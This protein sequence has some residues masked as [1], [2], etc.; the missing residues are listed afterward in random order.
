MPRVILRKGETI[1]VSQ[2]EAEQLQYNIESKAYKFTDFVTIRNQSV[3]FNTIERV[4]LDSAQVEDINGNAIAKWHNER[5]AF[6]A[7]S[8][9]Y[10]T[11]KFLEGPALLFF[12]VYGREHEQTLKERVLAFYADHP[13]RAWPD[14]TIFEGLWGNKTGTKYDE[15]GL[16]ILDQTLTEDAMSVKEDEKFNQKI[17]VS[18]EQALNGTPNANLPF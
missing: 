5:R 14:G 10:K 9:E 12:N 11:Q 7:K 4:V 13:K 3:R 16:R 1:E 8:P 15:A 18:Q 17:A 6:A 2:S